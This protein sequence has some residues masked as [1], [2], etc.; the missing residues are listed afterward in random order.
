MGAA[1]GLSLTTFGFHWIAHKLPRGGSAIESNKLD[2][3]GQSKDLQGTN[4][5]P[6]NINLVPTQTMTR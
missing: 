5:E 6:V 1:E 2:T 3:M 4:T